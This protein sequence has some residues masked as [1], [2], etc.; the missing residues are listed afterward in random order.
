MLEGWY[1]N[2]CSGPPVGGSAVAREPLG[3]VSSREVARSVKVNVVKVSKCQAKH[4]EVTLQ[5]TSARGVAAAVH[6]EGARHRL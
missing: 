5:L 3:F 2:C 6:A 4:F 1:P